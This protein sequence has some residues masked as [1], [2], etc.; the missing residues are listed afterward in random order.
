MKNIK[1][2][3]KTKSKN[4]H[5]TINIMVTI[6]CILMILWFIA[7]FIYIL[8]TVSDLFSIG[9][10]KI[11]NLVIAGCQIILPIAVVSILFIVIINLITRVEDCETKISKEILLRQLEEKKNIGKLE[12]GDWKCSKCGK[13]N[14]QYVGI[15]GCGAEKN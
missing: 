8:G 7:G 6:A 12:A 10:I 11:L 1:V 4:S 13:I 9:D 2:T 15:C 3:K 5:R 14:K